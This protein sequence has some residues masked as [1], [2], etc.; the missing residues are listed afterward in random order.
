[1]EFSLE[2][3]YLKLY[4][5][6]WLGEIFKFMVFILLENTCASQKIE[7]RYFYLCCPRQNSPAGSYQPPGRRK[8]L[9]P[10]AQKGGRGN[11][12]S[13]ILICLF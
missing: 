6:I 8:L 1:M 4:I 9:I 2:A 10:P 7:S 5:S 3:V 13:F 12:V 11:Y